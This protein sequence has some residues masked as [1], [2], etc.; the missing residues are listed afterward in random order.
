[1]DF[2]KLLDIVSQN[3]KLPITEGIIEKHKGLVIKSYSPKNKEVSLANV[4]DAKGN[5]DP[6]LSK[7]FPQISADTEEE[8][9]ELQKQAIDN[10]FTQKTV[11]TKNVSK[12][13]PNKRLQAELGLKP[14][15]WTKVGGDKEFYISRDPRDGFVKSMEY[16]DGHGF[17][18][19]VKK[20]DLEEAGFE[21]GTRYSV[22]Q[23]DTGSPDIIG[24]KCEEYEKI[25]SSDDKDR[26]NKPLV[27]VQYAGR[28]LD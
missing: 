5:P 13:Y 14:P 4:F 10:Y 9:L 8:A 15:I 16:E 22:K 20:K 17:G 2:R 24:L 1:M 25:L 18:S 12:I 26:G 21:L 19:P 11:N 3:S 27:V 23:F 7:L 28:N 6:K